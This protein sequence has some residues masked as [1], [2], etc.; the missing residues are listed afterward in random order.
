MISYV[1]VDL[2]DDVQIRG[3]GQAE[4]DWA[5]RI[6]SRKQRITLF[7]DE[8]DSPKVLRRLAAEAL[9]LALRMDNARSAAACNRAL[10]KSGAARCEA[11]GE[12]R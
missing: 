8:P 4:G 2:P 1:A 11:V 9:E 10:D 5:L 12:G 3:D 6:S 7:L